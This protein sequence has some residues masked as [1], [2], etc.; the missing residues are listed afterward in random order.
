MKFNQK[1]IL[2]GF[3]VFIALLTL[4]GALSAP[5][6]AFSLPNFNFF[7]S[8]LSSDLTQQALP[9]PP[10]SA[11]SAYSAN[12]A[13]Q[14][15]QGVVSYQETSEFAREKESVNTYARSK[16]FLKRLG[17][18]KV[19]VFERDTQQWFTVTIN[20]E[21]GMVER[22]VVGKEPGAEA[23]V[24]VSRADLEQVVSG[25]GDPQDKALTIIKSVKAPF[26]LTVKASLALIGL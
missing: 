3:M 10:T 2:A 9:A 23:E 22:V 18:S 14:V 11:P 8:R 1:P 24:S 21:S 5:V 17:L 16:K 20:P 13:G 7:K 15:A 4:I 25:G 6:E 12:S 26:G 19:A